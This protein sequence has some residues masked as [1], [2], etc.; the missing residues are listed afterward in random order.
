MY[1]DL[2][3][4]TLLSTAL[5]KIRYEFVFQDVSQKAFQVSNL[6]HQ[7]TN[8]LFQCQPE[9]SCCQTEISTCEHAKPKQIISGLAL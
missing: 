8:L 2:G 9:I 7:T 1:S 4:S 5:E 6:R 3:R